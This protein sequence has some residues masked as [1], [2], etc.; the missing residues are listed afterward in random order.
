MKISYVSS[1][2]MSNPQ[3]WAKNY[4]GLGAAGYNITKH[5]IDSHTSVNYVSQ[6]KKKFSVLTRIK[7]D[8][9]RHIFH[10]KYYR[11]AEK[12]IVKN[13]AH[14]VKQK[15][16]N[17]DTDL[18]LCTE[19]V[20]P[21]AYLDCKQPIVLWL[22]STLSSLIN[23][24]SYLDN[25]CDEN[26]RSIY[27]IEATALHRCSLLIYT[28]EWAAKNAIQ[29]YGVSPSKVK[30]IPWGGNLSDDKNINE[31][32]K[33]IDSRSQNKCKLLFLGVDWY[34]KGGDIAL[35]VV[36]ELNKQGLTTELTIVGCQPIVDASLP[37]Y[38]KLCGFIN[39]STV[40][41]RQKIDNLLSE[42]H[43]LILPSSA[44]CSPLVL[45][46]ANFFG[47]PCLST[48]IGGIPSIIKENINGK[49]FDLNASIEEYSRYIASLFSDYSRYR[50]LAISSFNEY[51]SR[52]NWNVAVNEAKQ[53][54]YDLI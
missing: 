13:Y 4:Q 17:L 29:T 42:S 36:E 27:E 38:V 10:K 43:F 53:L 21:I 1:I 16:S 12:P 41:G 40:E 47:T 7:W 52:L 35:K 24:Y 44:D 51:K 15:I 37:D 22:D 49:T 46:E 39:K 50:S 6:F 9:Y 23:F 11:W 28:S 8:I 14:Q 2:N 20:L 5:L 30:V 31:I 32:E 34:R 25:L 48:N 19:N 3:K 54:M 18:I 33:I 45:I 26:I